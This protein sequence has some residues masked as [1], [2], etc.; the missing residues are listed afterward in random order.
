MEHNTQQKAYLIEQIAPI[1]K[2]Y[3]ASSNL[4]ITDQDIDSFCNLGYGECIS[5]LVK[6]AA[7]QLKSLG[8]CVIPKSQFEGHSL[9]F[10]NEHTAFRFDIVLQCGSSAQQ[11]TVVVQPELLSPLGLSFLSWI[12]FPS[13]DNISMM[14]Y[15]MK[16]CRLRNCLVEL[17]GNEDRSFLDSRP[18]SLVIPLGWTFWLGV[19]MRFVAEH[20][21]VCHHAVSI[22]KPVLSRASSIIKRRPVEEVKKRWNLFLHSRFDDREFTDS[23]GEFLFLNKLDYELTYI[24]RLV[25]K[26]HLRQLSIGGEAFGFGISVSGELTNSEEYDFAHNHLM[27]GKVGSPTRI[28]SLNHFVALDMRSKKWGQIMRRMEWLRILLMDVMIFPAGTNTGFLSAATG[29]GF[30]YT[31][32]NVFGQS[33]CAVSSMSLQRRNVTQIGDEQ[34]IYLHAKGEDGEP[35]F[36]ISCKRDDQTEAFEDYRNGPHIAYTVRLDGITRVAQEE[37]T[38]AKCLEKL[39]NCIGCGLGKVCN[40]TCPSSQIGCAECGARC[41]PADINIA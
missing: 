32:C 33:D 34:N 26:Q 37:G 31:E 10:E 25:H 30:G 1:L 28:V 22:A 14:T 39:S 8:M 29:M 9:R 38:C 24:P 23:P 12:V 21:I 18:V 2:S 41:T 4:D 19:P 5:I 36:K 27:K 11:S 6:S 40:Q 15:I 17:V 3:V 16:R 35:G 13:P 20:G 7:D